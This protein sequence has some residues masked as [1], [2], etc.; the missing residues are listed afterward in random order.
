MQQAHSIRDLVGDPP[1]VRISRV[2][3][4]LGP[5][6]RQRLVLAECDGLLRRAA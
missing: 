4:G 1:L 6:E 5:P 2:T 3:R